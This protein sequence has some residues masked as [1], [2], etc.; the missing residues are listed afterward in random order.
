LDLAFF[1]LNPSDKI[2]IYSEIH[3]LIFHGNGGFS[4]EVV[5]NMPIWLRKYHINRIKEWHDKKGDETST[6]NKPDN[7]P[8]G[9][10]VENMS[11]YTGKADYTMKAPKK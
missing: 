4:Y 11:G 7:M 2:Y 8:L 9:P 6:D 10:G 3:E 5:F 1:G